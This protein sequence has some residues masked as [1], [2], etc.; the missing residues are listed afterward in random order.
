MDDGKVDRI[1]A[2]NIRTAKSGNKRKG[3]EC[4]GRTILKPEKDQGDVY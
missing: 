3:E 4:P 1:P 2:A